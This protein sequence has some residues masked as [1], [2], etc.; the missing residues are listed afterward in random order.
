MSAEGARLQLVLAELLELFISLAFDD[1]FAKLYTCALGTNCSDVL[2]I[3]QTNLA[4]NRLAMLFSGWLKLHSALLAEE[5][6]GAL[7]H[8]C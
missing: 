5:F 7:T 1:L 8:Q 3:R 2:A 6:V 4:P